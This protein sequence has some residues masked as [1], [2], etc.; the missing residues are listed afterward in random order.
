MYLLVAGQ[1][2]IKKGQELYRGEEEAGSIAPRQ[3]P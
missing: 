1:K 3:K 2:I